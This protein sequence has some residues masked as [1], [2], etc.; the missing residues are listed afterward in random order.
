MNRPD[1][2]YRLQPGGSLR[3]RLRVPGDKSISHRAVMF[4]ALAEGVTRVDGFLT[5]ED[6][7]STMQAFQAMGVG[8][9][10]TAETSLR[11]EGVGLNGLQAPASTLN[12]GNSGT[13]MRLMTGL[14]AG[15][16]F[17][18][19][20]IG[21]ISLSKRPM[22]RIVDPLRSMGARIDTAEKGTAPL[23]VHGGMALHGIDYRSPVASA[24]IKSSLLLAG[25]YAQGVTRVTEPGASRDHSERMLRAFGVEIEAVPGMAAVQGGQRLRATHIEVPADISSAAFFMVGAAIQPGSDILLEAVGVNPTRNGVI[26]ILRR[27]GADIELLDERLLGGEPVANIRVR[28]GTLRGIDIGHEL[29][30]L[31]I[32]EMPAIFVAA[33]CAQGETLVRDA[34]EL[35]VKESDRIQ[36]MCDGLQILGV[37]AKAAADG[38]RI[39][40]GRIGQGRVASQGDHRIAMSFSIAALRAS[41]PLEILDCANVNTSFPGFVSLARSA[42]LLIEEA[43][44]PD[45]RAV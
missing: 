12:L 44:A 16:R 38:A 40:G 11:I 24:Q 22:L 42:G 3:G 20:M 8:I 30:T 41:G 9:A 1:L 37:D 26:Q 25:L 6:C 23:H 34:A 15:Q 45:G 2:C 36:G 28:G 10:Q 4:G 43:P 17:D 39:R 29:V 13:S 7:L 33:A 14:M 35:R 18:T 19:H 32:D 5:G 31:A 21:D 27:M